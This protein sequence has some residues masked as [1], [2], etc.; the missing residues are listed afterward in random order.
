MAVTSF[1]GHAARNRWHRRCS[2]FDAMKK[3]TKQKLALKTQTIRVLDQD[4]LTNAAGGSFQPVEQGFIMKDTIIVRPT[5][6]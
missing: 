2:T 1:R 5:S 6:R 3:T 4:A